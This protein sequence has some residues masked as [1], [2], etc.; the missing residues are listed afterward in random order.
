M[1]ILCAISNFNI[2]EWLIQ[3]VP[4]VVVLSIVV[5]HLWK[6]YKEE[7]EY[8]K[9]QDKANLEHLGELTK[10]LDNLSNFQKLN[11][12]EL[13]EVAARVASLKDVVTERSETILNH[14]KNNRE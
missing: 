12:E 9:K 5:Y 13:K 11:R 7:V 10:V 1:G 8:N 14:L 3:Q 4:V 6:A 2:G